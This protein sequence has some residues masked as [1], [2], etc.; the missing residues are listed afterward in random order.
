MNRE[1]ISSS[2]ILLGLRTAGKSDIKDLIPELVYGVSLTHPAKMFSE[3]SSLVFCDSNFAQKKNKRTK[4]LKHSF[5][6]VHGTEKVSCAVIR[7][8][9]LMSFFE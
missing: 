2:A 5:T 1:L 6:P 3:I 4:N 7:R 9:T 8:V